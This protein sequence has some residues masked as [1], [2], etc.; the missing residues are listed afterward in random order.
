MNATMPC[1]E[2]V[3]LTKMCY[4]DATEDCLLMMLE[5]VSLT[6]MCYN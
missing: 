1:L 3:S 6:K 2:D 5:D 4:N